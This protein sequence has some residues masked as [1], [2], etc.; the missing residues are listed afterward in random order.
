MQ[1]LSEVCMFS[2]DGSVAGRENMICRVLE[3]I[4]E[5]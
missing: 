1:T 2:E 3:G 5:M 4:L